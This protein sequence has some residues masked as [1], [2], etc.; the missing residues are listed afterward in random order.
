[1]RVSGVK[2]VTE[3][4]LVDERTLQNRRRFPNSLTKKF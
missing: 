1:L 4:V 3:E 2:C